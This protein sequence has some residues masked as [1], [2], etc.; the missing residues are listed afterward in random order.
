MALLLC[1][2]CQRLKSFK[3]GEHDRVIASCEAYPDGIPEAIIYAGHLY[4][5]PGDNGLKFLKKNDNIPDYLQQSEQ[6]ENEHYEKLSAHY[7]ELDMTDDEWLKF[8][9][10]TG[11][12]DYEFVKTLLPFRPR[13]ETELKV[14]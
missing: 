9:C 12:L 4:S 7:T 8:K 14:W 13:R 6:E 2:L 11:N 5:K 10:E 1:N 3:L